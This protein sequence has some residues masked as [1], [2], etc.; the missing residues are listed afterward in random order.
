VNNVL[1]AQI[2]RICFV[3]ITQ[4]EDLLDSIRINAERA[5]I[6]AGVFVLIGAL[7]NVVIGCYKNGEYAHTR[8]DGPLEIASCTGNIAVDDNGDT[9]IHAHIVVANEKGQAFGGHLM[10]GSDVRPMAELMIIEASGAALTRVFDEKT[11][12]KLLK[13]G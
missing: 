5:N 7:K 3:R 13:L 10:K 4:N 9:V 6:R 12:L 8:L 11:K 1:K 2:G